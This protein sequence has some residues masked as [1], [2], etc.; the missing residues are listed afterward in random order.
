MLCSTRREHVERKLEEWR[1]AIEERGLKINRKKTDYL[2]CNQH[3]DADIHLQG[4]TVKRVKTFTYLGSTLV[5]DGE[6][7]VEV[8][9]RVQSGWKN[10]KS[11]WCY[12]YRVTTLYKPNMERC[13]YEGH[14]RGGSE[15]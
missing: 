4:D 12:S 7:D 9:R 6:L 11:V 1:R 14:D 2:A 5:D 10:Y 13:M 3:Q 15:R 8:T